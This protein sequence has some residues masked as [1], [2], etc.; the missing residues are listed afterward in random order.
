MR[1]LL[2]VPLSHLSPALIC[3]RL[4]AS[5]MDPD[6]SGQAYALLREARN[7]TYRWICEVQEKL[8]SVQDETSRASLQHRLC[9]LAATC[10]STFDVCSEHVDA[11][12]VNK[13]DFSIAMQC[14]VVVHDNTPQS[15]PSKSSYV[16]RLLSRHRRL[17]HTLEPI[18]GQSLPPVSGRVGLSHT[19]AYDDALARL[20]LGNH[21]GNSESLSWH[22]LPRPN[23]RWI[24]C[25]TSEGQEVYYDIL[26]GKLIVDGKCLGRL[27]QEIAKHPT[28][29]SVFGT[30]SVEHNLCPVVSDLT[31]RCFQRI[32]DVS[33]ADVHGMDY[34][35]RSPE[36]GYQV[37]H[38]CGVPLSGH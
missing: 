15:L 11:V 37:R 1:F 29:T 7:V 35:A 13:E 6:V 2:S 18:F 25:V 31:W 8:D 32:L 10:L 5:T 34:M 28:Y 9:M 27:P 24:S 4:L 22:S 30:V 26:T 20:R 17:L 36:S 21:Q 12:L 14:A 38:C 19:S 23:S 33:P 16:T 3:S